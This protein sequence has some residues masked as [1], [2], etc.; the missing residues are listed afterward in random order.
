MKAKLFGNWSQ[1]IVSQKVQSNDKKLQLNSQRKPPARLVLCKK[2]MI[3]LSLKFA[4]C[5]ENSRSR[6][7]MKR[8]TQLNFYSG[9]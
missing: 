5:D 6:S 1:E 4:C 2:K 7:Y 9:P 3:E 8:P